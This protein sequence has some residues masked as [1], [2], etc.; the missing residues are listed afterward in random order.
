MLIAA[1]LDV[2][3]EAICTQ[4]LFCFA[5]GSHSVDCCTVQRKVQTEAASKARISVCKINKV[6]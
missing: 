1:I 3:L 2:I 4:R 6:I 5:L